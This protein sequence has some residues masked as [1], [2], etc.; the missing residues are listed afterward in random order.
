MSARLALIVAMAKNRVIGRENDMPW[1]IPEDLRHFK[2]LT[3][4]KP[5][6]MGRKTF[7]SITARL[8][9]PLPGRMNIVISRSAPQ[10]PP[11]VI[12]CQGL[13]QALD[14]ARAIA[15]E[16]G[17][18]EIFV[19]G[20]AQIYALALP[21]AERVYLTDIG[22]EIAGDAFFPALDPALWRESEAR[23]ATENSDYPVVFRTF[24]RTGNA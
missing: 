18:D 24:C 19:I 13:E 1:H 11:G 17:A 20:G 12:C 6:I 23:P 22:V 3:L 7:D 15:A 9:K 14:K 10:L 21:L 2:A 4:G 8:G 5:V 16:T